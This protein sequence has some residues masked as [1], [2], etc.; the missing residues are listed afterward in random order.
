[1]QFPGLVLLRTSSS[2]SNDFH[3]HTFLRRTGLDLIS[4]HDY[5]AK[6]ANNHV[7]CTQIAILC[8]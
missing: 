5:L 2:F 4:A 7:I 3:L 6:Q 1:M 8:C